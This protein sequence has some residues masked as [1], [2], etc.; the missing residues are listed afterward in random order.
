MKCTGQ[1]SVNACSASISIPENPT[2]L[3]FALSKWIKE[4][5]DKYLFGLRC[6]IHSYGML[7]R[8][9][10]ICPMKWLPTVGHVQR[11]I[12]SRWCEVRL[13]GLLGMSH[14]PQLCERMGARRHYHTIHTVLRFA[15][16]VKDEW[17]KI[18]GSFSLISMRPIHLYRNNEG[19]E[20]LRDSIS[21]IL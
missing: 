1:T 2:S 8:Q 7:W 18:C 5:V 12:L 16:T 10:H 14:S 15:R 9:T 21:S 11:F 6:T 20:D 4:G 13:I 19:F 3:T 17:S